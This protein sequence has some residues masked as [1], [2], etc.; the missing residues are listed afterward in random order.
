MLHFFITYKFSILGTDNNCFKPGLD[1]SLGDIKFRSLNA[2]WLVHCRNEL[3]LLSIIL[4]V[5]FNSM[6][7]LLM[8][9]ILL[10]PCYGNFHLYNRSTKYPR[11]IQ[12]HALMSFPADCKLLAFFMSL[13]GVLFR[14][15]LTQLIIVNLNIVHINNPI[16]KKTLEICRIL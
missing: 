14:F 13:H 7:M 12:T 3:Q 10:I 8:M 9:T 11:E 4:S 2:W 1:Y 15:N 16:H 6:M 5:S